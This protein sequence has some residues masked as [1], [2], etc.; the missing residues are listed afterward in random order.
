MISLV[1]CILGKKPRVEEAKVLEVAEEKG[2]VEMGKV[3]GTSGKSR[4]RSWCTSTTMVL[5]DMERGECTSF[6]SGEK[7]HSN[8]QE[9]HR[10]EPSAQ[11]QTQWVSSSTNNAFAPLAMSIYAKSIGY[12]P[13]GTASASS[14]S[15]RLPFELPLSR[16]SYLKISRLDIN[17]CEDDGDGSVSECACELCRY[18]DHARKCHPMCSFGGFSISIRTNFGG[19][20]D[21]NDMIGWS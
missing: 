21:A 10:R 2:E 6:G 17:A 3:K 12:M 5:K 14:S 16:H 4:E 13:S 7:E 20:P 18:A 9:G 15:S 11:A 1:G 19:G 8:Y